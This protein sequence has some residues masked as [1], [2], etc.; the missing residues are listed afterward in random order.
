[1]N[2]SRLDGHHHR[3]HVYFPKQT[4]AANNNHNPA[5]RKSHDQQSW[6]PMITLKCGINYTINNTKKR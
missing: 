3:R 5:A 6:L 4:V 1:M 2:W